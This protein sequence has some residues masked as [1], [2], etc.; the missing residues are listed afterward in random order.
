MISKEIH[1]LKYLEED[2][3][4]DLN[5]KLSISSIS[6]LKDF[7]FNNLEEIKNAY[8]SK[9][10]SLSANYSYERLMIYATKSE[11]RINFFW[12]TLPFIVIAANLIWAFLSKNWILILGGLTGL[13]GYLSSSP[14]FRLRNSLSGL[15]TLFAIVFIFI[16]WELAVILG[17]YSLSLIFTM[18]VRKSYKQIIIDRALSS[19][20]FFIWLFINRALLIRDNKTLNFIEPQI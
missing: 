1:Y 13:L 5:E 7:P 8:S 15:S 4:K 2:F 16:N 12:L 20:T 19:E 17:S 18:T 11:I 14:Y 10:I 6:D 3:K 9:I